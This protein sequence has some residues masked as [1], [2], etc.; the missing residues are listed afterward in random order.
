MAWRAT[1]GL[2]A[3]MS[4]STFSM[5]GALVTTADTL[6]CTAQPT[7]HRGRMFRLRRHL[8]TQSLTLAS[9]LGE[10][11]YPDDDDDAMHG[12]ATHC[13]MRHASRE[14]ELPVILA[15]SWTAVRWD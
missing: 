7:G 11:A 8:T 15:T 1:C 5:M 9:A 3:N 2:F 6:V 12:V 4:Q 14:P 10:L 13:N